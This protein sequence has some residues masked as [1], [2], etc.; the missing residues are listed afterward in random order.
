MAQQST[1]TLTARSGAWA[2]GMVVVYGKRPAILVDALTDSAYATLGIEH[3]GILF[4]PDSV[5]IPQAGGV[6]ATLA[7]VGQSVR[8]RSVLSKRRL[9]KPLLAA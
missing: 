6:L 4:G 1:D 5:L 7:L 9:L 8:K 3:L 2:A